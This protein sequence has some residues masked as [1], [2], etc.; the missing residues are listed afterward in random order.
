MPPN[1][2][3][4]DYPQYCHVPAGWGL[5][6]TTRAPGRDETRGQGS[7]GP[8]TGGPNL[9]STGKPPTSE[10][11]KRTTGFTYVSLVYTNI[12]IQDYTL[13]NE[14]T[15]SLQ[16]SDSVSLSAHWVWQTVHSTYARYQHP[17]MV[18]L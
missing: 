8:L 5:Q 14:Q 9:A 7:F 6:Q 16:L 11:H 4:I 18:M 2:V 13:E 17:L 12:F 10:L 1:R 3:Q 15:C